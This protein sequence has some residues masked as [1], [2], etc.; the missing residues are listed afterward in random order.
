M[1]VRAIRF[2]DLPVITRGAAQATEP[3]VVIRE[4]GQIA[5]N[6]LAVKQTFNTSHVMVQ[7]DIPDG[8][9]IG[10][11]PLK[12]VLIPVSE[13]V[14][15]TETSK[16]EGKGNVVVELKSGEKGNSN[17][18]VYFSGAALLRKL[19][20][21]Y[22]KSGNHTFDLALGG[23]KKDV[24]YITITEGEYPAAPKRPRVSKPKAPV[25]PAVVPAPEVPATPTPAPTPVQ[26]SDD[27]EL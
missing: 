22:G 1:S 10:Q 12:L 19:G 13:E 18:G 17:K 25:V 3:K 23:K 2:V 14:Y 21:E 7:V 26:E 20:Y 11:F 8:Q 6:S 16:P 9:D 24:P 5:F 4:N 15:K 27:I